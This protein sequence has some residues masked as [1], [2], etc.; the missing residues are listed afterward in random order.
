[1][2]ESWLGDEQ[3][4]AVDVEDEMFREGTKHRSLAFMR[5]RR[6]VRSGY[7]G[8]CCHEKIKLNGASPMSLP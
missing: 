5:G 7:D 3:R 4:F 8:K 6:R 1:L 2:A